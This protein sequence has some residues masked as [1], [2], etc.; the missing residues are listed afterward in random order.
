MGVGGRVSSQQ[1]KFIICR[2]L[3]VEEETKGTGKIRAEVSEI[4]TGEE[5]MAPTLM[6]TGEEPMALSPWRP[7]GWRLERSPWR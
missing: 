4:E 5:P 3:K 6:E 7:H 2:H 1:S